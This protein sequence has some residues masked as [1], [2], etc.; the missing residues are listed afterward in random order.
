MQLCR[1][2]IAQQAALHIG[3]MSD[4]ACCPADRVLHA[5]WRSKW[6]AIRRKIYHI[7]MA[8]NITAMNHFFHKAPPP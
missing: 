2:R 3:I 7:R 8:V 1:Q 4:L 6:I 5:L